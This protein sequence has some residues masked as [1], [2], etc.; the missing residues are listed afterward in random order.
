MLSLVSRSLPVASGF[1]ASLGTPNVSMENILE[2]DSCSICSGDEKLLDSDD[3][4]TGKG[5]VG[6][7]G[8]T[9]GKG[10]VNSGAAGGGRAKGRGTTEKKMTRNEIKRLAEAKRMK[11][12]AHE[13]VPL[14]SNS[15]PVPQNAPASV[16][17]LEFALEKA[18]AMGL[19]EQTETSDPPL[20]PLC[21]RTQPVDGADA[22]GIDVQ[23]TLDWTLPQDRPATS[24]ELLHLVNAA[25]AA[26]HSGTG[27]TDVPVDGEDGLCLLYTSDAADE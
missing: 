6:S 7:E 1:L 27:V 3:E 26:M 12:V 21:G 19:D 5:G 14:G 2:G 8:T 4:M 9:I 18:A 17:D 15:V 13:A 24:D 11:E 16:T 23:E 25:S 20:E 10:R 22:G